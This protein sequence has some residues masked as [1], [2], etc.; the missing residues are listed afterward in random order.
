MIGVADGCAQWLFDLGRL[1]NMPGT[2]AAVISA[3]GRHLDLGNKELAARIHPEVG[4]IV[5]R[6]PPPT[7]SRVITEQR[8]T[9]ACTPSL[10]RP[11]TATALPGLWLAGDYVS[12]DYPATIEGA[13]R[14]GV[15]AAA[16]VLRQTPRNQP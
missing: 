16:S 13:V 4:R 15:A 2:I 12:G 1:R 14:S 11:T 9:F 8:A 10:Q 7:W 6:L 5:P 3:R